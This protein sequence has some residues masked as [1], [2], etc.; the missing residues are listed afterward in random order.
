[1]KVKA[2]ATASVYAMVLSVGL[3]MLP[4]LAA[5]EETSAD[6]SVPAP[7]TVEEALQH[8]EGVLNTK[9]EGAGALWTFPRFRES[10]TRPDS[11]KGEVRTIMKSQTTCG[12][13]VRYGDTIRFNEISQWNRNVYD[14]GDDGEL[15]LTG[16]FDGHNHLTF[17]IRL[18]QGQWFFE[19]N[20][21]THNLPYYRDVSFGQG[22]V[23]WLENGFELSGVGG[24]GERFG[25]EGSLI[26][27]INY[28]QLKYVRDGEQLI[29]SLNTQD[30]HPVKG[31]QGE[32]LAFPDFD[33]PIGAPFSQE[34]ISEVRPDEVSED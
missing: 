2:F 10:T 17:S 9:Q 26:L 7:A 4:P 33:E 14:V 28:F 12:G 20:M 19:R 8:I 24:L 34:S 23:A 27:S 18:F 5:Q 15:T 13:A 31:P 22:S 25:P 32:L 21:V 6:D 11:K 1:M 16:R 30:Y 3:T 29:M